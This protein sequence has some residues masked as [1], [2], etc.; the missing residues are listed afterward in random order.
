MYK[1]EA[2]SEDFHFSKDKRIN[3]KKNDPQSEEKFADFPTSKAKR[4]SL[5]T[6][7]QNFIFPKLKA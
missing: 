1:S 7:L 3:L 4:R 5:K 6:I 2:N